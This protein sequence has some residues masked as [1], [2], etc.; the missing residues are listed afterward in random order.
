MN[1]V[2]ENQAL[3]AAAQALML[4]LARLLVAR[5]VPYAQA[6]ESLKA[7]MV[8]AAREAH[9]DG[10]PHRLV[11]RI[12]TTTGINRREVTRLT[13]SETALAQPQRSA[14][15]QLFTRWRTADPYRDAQGQPRALPRQGDAPSFDSLARSIT[16]DVHPRSLLD[17]L[18]RLGLVSHDAASDLVTL[19]LDAFVPSADRARMLE[20]LAHNVGDHLSAAVANVLGPAP[21][22]L[23]R[24]VFA[25]GLSPVAIAAAEAWVAD[26]WR[27]LLAGLVP[28][29]ET[30]IAAEAHQP[31]SGRQQRFRAGLYAYTARD[32]D[33]PSKPPAA[34]AQS[35]PD[36]N[37]RPRRR[38]QPVAD[39]APRPVRPAKTAKTPRTR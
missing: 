24:A 20:F 29:L 31:A 3:I 6:E 15:A 5:G 1:D 21:R 28:V 12:A 10:L 2:D 30:L 4:P 36:A 23:E 37:T 27:G 34:E 8:E 39:D 35:T 14:A 38:A 7:S 9:P 16:Q 22:H 25:D 17:E 26:A 18:L 32:D 11:S 19:S 13:R 33:A